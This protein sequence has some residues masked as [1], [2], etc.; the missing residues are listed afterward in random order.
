M[1]SNRCSK[2]KLCN[3]SKK[4]HHQLSHLPT[5]VELYYDGHVDNDGQFVKSKAKEVWK[6][7]AANLECE[8]GGWNEKGRI[9]GLGVAAHSYYDRPTYWNEKGKKSRRDCIKSLETQVVEL[10]AKNDDQ[11][12]ELDLTK[13]ELHQTK[14]REVFIETRRT[15][16]E[17]SESFMTFKQQVETFMQANP[18]R[19]SHH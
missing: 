4:V 1:R 10:A 6:K 9:F 14:T 11:K 16:T 5:A 19:S 17:T 8:M 12:K 15:L 3:G 13:H 2:N 7:K 18:R